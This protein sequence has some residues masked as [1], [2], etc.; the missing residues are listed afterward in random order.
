MISWPHYIFLDF[1]PCFPKSKVF[2]LRVESFCYIREHRRG[3]GEILDVGLGVNLM[4]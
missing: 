3:F 4:Y 1:L 2:G